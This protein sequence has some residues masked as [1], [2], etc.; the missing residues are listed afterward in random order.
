LTRSHFGNIPSVAPWS[1]GTS[2][3]K[4]RYPEPERAYL[5]GL[6]HDLGELVNSIAVPDLFLA[7]SERARTQNEPFYAAE[8]AVMG[9]THCQS[10]VYLAERWKLPDELADT[11]AHHH[12]IEQ[13]KRNLPLV[14]IVRLS[15]LLFSH[16]GL[17]YDT[18]VPSPAEIAEDSAWIMLEGEYPGVSHVNPDQFTADMDAFVGEVGKLVDAIFRY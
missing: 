12:D 5:A 18:Y 4:I 15:D 9:F 1:A 13:A 16:R 8:M 14:A 10:G 17:T 2:R 6:L 11:I 7:A 3:K